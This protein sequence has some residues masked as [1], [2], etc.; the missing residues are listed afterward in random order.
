MILQLSARKR[1]ARFWNGRDLG[2]SASVL[3]GYAR[4]LSNQIIARQVSASA[5]AD[6]VIPPRWVVRDT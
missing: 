1:W 5:L 6:F 3:A 2:C 4:P